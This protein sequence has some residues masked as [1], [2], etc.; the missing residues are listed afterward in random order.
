MY[1]VSLTYFSYGRPGL[2]FR[3]TTESG[4][5]IK[6]LFSFSGLHQCISVS[7][8]NVVMLWEMDSEGQPTITSTKEFKL[9]PEG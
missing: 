8:D 9:D 5:A 1:I 3:A 2:E 6:E 7:E 4:T